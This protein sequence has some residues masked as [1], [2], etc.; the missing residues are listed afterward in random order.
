MNKLL[1][2]FLSIFLF[3]LTSQAEVKQTLE[4]NL[5]YAHAE[6][7]KYELDEDN[8]TLNDRTRTRAAGSALGI[9]E[10]S[11]R[12]DDFYLESEFVNVYIAGSFTGNVTMT[13]GGFGF[14]FGL[15]M[16]HPDSVGQLTVDESQQGSYGNT[17]DSHRWR[18]GPIYI[19]QTESSIYRIGLMYIKEHNVS[20]FV[21]NVGSS[22]DHTGLYFEA[23]YA[24]YFAKLSDQISLGSE[25]DLISLL[26]SD[27][28]IKGFGTSG[29]TEIKPDFKSFY[30]AT[31]YPLKLRISF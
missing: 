2:I 25:L 3:P 6:D 29:T 7:G 13:W 8:V 11:L 23:S 5:L 12:A 9:F 22:F 15:G 16:S 31:V 28:S 1:S 19:G 17:Q 26:M 10:Y 30:T 18:L 24:Y 4:L 21:N 14:K 20:D 27:V